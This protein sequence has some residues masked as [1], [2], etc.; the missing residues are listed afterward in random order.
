MGGKKSLLIISFDLHG[1][2]DDWVVVGTVPKQV[3]A[4]FSEC[5]GEH[6]VLPIVSRPCLFC[7]LEHFVGPTINRDVEQFTIVVAVAAATIFDIT[8]VVDVEVA[9]HFAAL[10]HLKALVEAW[11]HSESI[12]DVDNA[13]IFLFHQFILSNGFGIVVVEVG[14]V[15]RHTIG[16]QVHRGVVGVR[17]FW[18][19]SRLLHC[20]CIAGLNRS[21][22]QCN[23]K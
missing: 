4:F 23:H 3:A 17:L 13:A 10:S 19:F 14:P 22:Q 11:V 5:V 16:P 9:S 12:L 18:I 21:H 8:V 7:M 1:D 15:R 20:S 6:D 2:F